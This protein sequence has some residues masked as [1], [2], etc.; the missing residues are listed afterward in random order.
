MPARKEIWTAM[1][2]PPRPAR[3]CGPLVLL[4]TQSPVVD[5]EGLAP[6]LELALVGLKGRAV[7]CYG[8]RS[9]KVGPQRSAALRYQRWQRRALLLSY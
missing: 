2:V 4:L 7:R 3:Y 1:P 6:P 8:N 5:R 9:M